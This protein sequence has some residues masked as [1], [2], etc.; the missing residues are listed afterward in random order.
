MNKNSNTSTISFYN[1]S[2]SYFLL[3]QNLASG[4]PVKIESGDVGRCGHFL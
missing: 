2:V 4:S 1:S 3:H